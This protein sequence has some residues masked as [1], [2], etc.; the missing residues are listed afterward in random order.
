[1]LKIIGNSAAAV[2]ASLPYAYYDNTTSFKFNDIDLGLTP[3]GG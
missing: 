2:I 1:M 3:L